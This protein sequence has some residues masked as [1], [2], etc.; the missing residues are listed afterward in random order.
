M[1]DGISNV[2]N[3]MMFVG[4][5]FRKPDLYLEYE[6][7]IKSKFY[8]T[9][10]VC[11]FFYEEGFLIY[12]NRTQTFTEVSIQLY[13][14]EDKDRLTKFREYGG[15]STIE[16]WM[17][18]AQIEDMQ[19]YFNV[20]QKFA[21]IREYER[22]GL[23]TERFRKS[24]KFESLTPKQ[25]YF[26]IKKTVD[27]IFTDISGDPDVETLNSSVTEMINQYLDKPAMGE[28]TPFFS[29]NDLFRGLRTGTAMGIGMTSNSG[30]TRFLTKLLG[31]LTLVRKEKCMVLLNE[32]SVE[33]IRL[34]L[35]TTCI[36][37]PE[38]VEIHKIEHQKDERELA[39]GLY[40]D[41]KGEIIYRKRDDITGEFVE[42]HQDY[43]NRLMK[44]SLDYNKVRAVAQWIEEQ[45]DNK[46][47]VIDVSTGYTDEDL[48]A[49]IRKA[50]TT[51][52][53]RYFFY[54]T[55]KNELG[56]IGEWAAL[57][58]TT[59]KLAELAKTLHV[60][61]LASLQLTDDVNYIE[62]L[63][64][65]SMNIAASKGLK[66]VL[67]SLTLWKEIDKKDYKRYFYIPTDNVGWGKQIETDLPENDDSNE[68]L[69]CC[70]VDKNRAGAKAKILFSVNLNTN[71]WSELGRIFKK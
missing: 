44:T 49:Y 2:P 15:Y 35:L 51:K 17:E 1:S 64:L 54:D 29:F 63:D 30:K 22:K 34:A 21:L 57:K 33:D 12:K 48:D 26:N 20:L 24:R 65:N 6:R 19:N 50:V 52:S 53:I 25:L 56:T 16:T 7:F 60:F 42:T 31:Y 4:A 36:N 45:I 71:K 40:R 37:N 14:S 58:Q 70:V 3:E 46:I 55:L 68:R 11:K 39:L 10:V 67:T 38:F 9:D 59:T 13:M 23:N 8:F 27:Q 47:F 69:Y 62:P 32:M 61:I 66:T 5:L 18:L 41:N 28:I 43:I